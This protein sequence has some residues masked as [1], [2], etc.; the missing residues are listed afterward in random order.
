MSILIVDDSQ[1]MQHMFR[2]ILGKA[3]YANIYTASS[4]EDA[5]EILGMKEETRATSKHVDD[6]ELIMLDIVMPGMDGIEACKAIKRHEKYKDIPVIFMT[7]NKSQIVEAFLAG[8]MDYIT[9][10]FENYELL[11]RVKSAITLNA[12]R[13]ERISREVKL[14]RELE[15]AKQVQ[16]IVLS[17]P[18]SD[19]SIQIHGKYMESDVVSGDMFY[20]TKVTEEQYAVLLLDVSGHG[21]SSALITMSARSLLE[22]TI[23]EKVDPNS[24]YRELNEQMVELFG[25]GK[26]LIYFTALYL[27][28]DVAAQTIQYF[29]AGHPPGLLIENGSI[30]RLANTTIPIGMKAK[31]PVRIESISYRKQ[32][33]LVLYTDGLVETPKASINTSINLLCEYLL[34]ID[35]QE[36]NETYLEEIVS[37]KTNRSDDI[38]IISIML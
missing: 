21:L 28:I 11:A 13:K 26:K 38:C 19:Q 32:T 14:R 33:R 25:S 3:G 24:V 17:K 37:F 7:A 29:N 6:I 12:E 10:D 36:D 5:F 15:L 8:G 27:L 1:L 20:W 34:Q 31:P 16:K 4:A 2:D 18:I 22:R 30:S 9:K 23:K 35:E